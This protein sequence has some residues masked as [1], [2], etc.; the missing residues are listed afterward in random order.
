MG[1]TGSAGC[2]S[3]GDSSTLAHRETF[4]GVDTIEIMSTKR[5]RWGAAGHLVEVS[6]AVTHCLVCGK[7]RGGGVTMCHDSVTVLIALCGSVNLQDSRGRI[8]EQRGRVPV[9]MFAHWECTHGHCLL[10]PTSSW[11]RLMQVFNKG[12]THLPDS[13]V[14]AGSIS[15]L[16]FH[17]EKV[18]KMSSNGTGITI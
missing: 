17:L 7:R 11:L 4:L 3:E 6:A 5:A 16:E 1:T 14:K 8:T 9:I 10:L 2:V 18:R 12:V 13:I 15:C